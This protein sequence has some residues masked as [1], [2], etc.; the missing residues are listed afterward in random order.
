MIIVWYVYDLRNVTDFL[1]LRQILWPTLIRNGKKAKQ[2][3]TK[4]NPLERL[5]YAFLNVSFASIK[6]SESKN[7]SRKF[8]DLITLETSDLKFYSA[9]EKVEIWGDKQQANVV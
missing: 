4:Q 3:K 7:G 8:M 5:Q 2:N 1:V 6:N 9:P